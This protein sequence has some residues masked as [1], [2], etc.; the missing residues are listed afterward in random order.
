V[1]L[2]RPAPARPEGREIGRSLGLGPAETDRALRAML[3]G[4]VQTFFDGR[5]SAEQVIDLVPVRP[6]AAAEPKV[7][8]VYLDAL[9]ALHA[10]L[11]G[12]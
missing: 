7:R 2:P 4:A 11:K 6:L 12:T 9:P 10:K 3:D 8:Q 1:G 5:L